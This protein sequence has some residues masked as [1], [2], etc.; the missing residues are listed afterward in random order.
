MCIRDRFK[1]QLDESTFWSGEPSDENDRPGMPER[2]QE[3]RTAL[4]QEDCGRA[5]CLGKEFVGN[6][7]QYGSSLPVANLFVV[8]SG[9]SSHEN[10][11]RY[12]RCL[13][14]TSRCV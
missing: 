1:V 6:Q 13:L 2:L 4:L 3:I 5:D 12:R 11:Q 14:Y 9:K 8:C 7:N 10:V